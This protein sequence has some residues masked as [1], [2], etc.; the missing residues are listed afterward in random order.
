MFARGR[1]SLMEALSEIR[2]EETRLRGAG[3]LEVPSVLATRASSTPPAAP[4]HSRSSAPPLLPTPS[5]GSGRPRPHCDYCNNDG[6]IE[7]QCYTK[8]KHLRKARSSSSGTPS[9]TSI[10][11][12]IALTEQDILQ[13]K[14][15]LAASSSSSTGIAGSVTGASRTEQPPSTQSGTSPWVLDSGASFHMS[16][17]S[18][19]LSS[20]RSLD[21]PVHVFTADGTPLSVASRGHLSTPYSVPDVAHV[22]RLTMNLFSAGQ[23]TDSGCRVILDVDSCSVQDRR[24]HTLVGAGPR[25]RDSQGLWELDW[26]HVPSAATTIASSSAAVA[27]VTGSFKQWHHR[28]GHLCGSRLS[29]LVRRGLLGSVSGDVSLECQGCRLGKQ[30]QLPYSHSESVS[31]RPF[32][33]VHSDVWG[34]APFAS[35]GGHKYYIIFI[36]DFSRYTWL[37]FMTSRSE[38][39]S[40]YKRFAAM[41]HTQFSS[42]IR[43]FRADSA[44]EY[45]SK[46]LRGV[47]A[48]QGT[49][50]QFSCPGAH[51]QNGVA[52]RKH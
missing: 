47:L 6:H 17:H 39:L 7:S 36:D 31:K 48:E 43:V 33:L 27:S 15:L 5:G 45:I 34:P 2:A 40:I 18:S 22:P 1:I 29:S 38:V 10:A 51:A 19:T 37:Y 11:S 32:D 8:R 41:V 24:T 49:L 52:E 12:A 50:S 23:L 14:R 44:G 42:P 21:S 35:K 3:L 25:R 46:M 4:P 20:L 26:L 30:I 28:L 13:L 9:S 16:S